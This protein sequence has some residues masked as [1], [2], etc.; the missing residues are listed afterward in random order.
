MI[1]LKS[2]LSGAWVD[3]QGEDEILVDAS[4]EETVAT[5]CTDGLDRDAALQHAREHGGPA[6][7]AMTFAERGAMLKAISKAIHDNREALIE[8]SVQGGTTRGDAK[9][10][11]DG[12]S[13]TL[14][15]YAGLGKRLGDRTFL[16]EG[17]GEQL[18]RSARFFGYHVKTPREGVAV[19]INA[20]NF[21]AWGLAE[22]AAVAWLAGVPVFSKPATP[23]ALLAFRIAETIVDTGVLPVGAFQFLCGAHGDV[24]DHLGPQ[25]MLAFTGS[26]RT[27][28]ILRRLAP[29]SDRHVRVNVEADSLNAVVIGEDVE[30]GSEVWQMA[31]RDIAREVT[32]KTGQ[33]CTAT[34]RVFVPRG[35]L[36]A[37]TEALSEEIGR[38]KIGHPMHDGVRMGPVASAAQQRS[39]KEG[40]ARFVEAGAT[41]AY[42]NDAA[43]IGVEPGKGFFVRPTLLV[44]EPGN[45]AVVHQEEIFGPVTTLLPYDSTADAVRFVAMGEGGLIAS[46]YTDDKKALKELVLGLAPWSGRLLCGTKKVA[47]QAIAPGM[48]L[49]SCVHGGPGRA[50]GGEE[51]GGER[52]LSFYLQR[53]AV[54]GDRALLMRVLGLKA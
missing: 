32:Q 16:V 45:V 23:T 2:Y 38:V 43:P 19:H 9:F 42:Q 5:T 47:D 17:E 15:Y 39:V 40:I 4:T 25:D 29:I 8:A 1:R 31:V 54:Q 20:F 28:A 37:L 36:E 26:G 50:G 3:G 51:L 14:A 49:P 44:A 18:T 46:I 52:G 6:L 10:D 53:T 12:A 41:L 13:G 30:V 22:K 34:R 27:G 35:A 24:L 21:P 33:K 7:R 48:V 11:I